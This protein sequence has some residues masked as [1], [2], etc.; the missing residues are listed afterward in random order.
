M[1]KKVKK[2]DFTK[3]ILKIKN[4]SQFIDNNLIQC[5]EDRFN[6]EF[7]EKMKE[8]YKEMSKINLELSQLSFEE[9]IANINE[10]ENW[11]CGV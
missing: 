10:Y 3:N 9:E 5:R 1:S 7:F 6:I 11:L 4:V 2:L 8:G